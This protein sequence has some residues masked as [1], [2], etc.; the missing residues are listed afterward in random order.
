VA[1]TVGHA[2]LGVVIRARPI[3]IFNRQIASGHVSAAARPGGCCDT[4]DLIWA[5]SVQAAALHF[6]QLGVAASEA[7]ARAASAETCPRSIGLVC[8]SWTWQ[9]GFFY[10]HPS[11]LS[12]WLFNLIFVS[13]GS[14]PV[15]GVDLDAC[16]VGELRPTT[17]SEFRDHSN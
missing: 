5:L 2:A 7:Q 11:I 17:G 6:V 1:P 8:M 15:R 13:L 9:I 14:D 10:S 16:I 3:V 4:T 12:L